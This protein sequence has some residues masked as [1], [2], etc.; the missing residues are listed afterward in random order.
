MDIAP[1]ELFEIWVAISI[2]HR[3][4]ANRQ[5]SLFTDNMAC[6][7]VWVSGSCKDPTM[8]RIIRPL[9]FICAR[10]NINLSLFHVDGHLNILA[11]HLSRTQLEKFR[12]AHPHAVL[13][14]T[15]ITDEVWEI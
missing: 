15:T 2:W 4:L 1:K 8:L 14:P 6:A 7:E 12:E 13:E 11:D 5:V 10:H 3:K 9:F